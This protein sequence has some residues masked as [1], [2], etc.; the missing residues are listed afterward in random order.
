MDDAQLREALAA[1][2]RGD[3]AAFEEIYAALSVP[4]YTIILRICGAREPAEDA[5]QEVFLKLFRAP[6]GPDVRKPRAYLFQMAR[7]QALDALRQRT[8]CEDLDDHRDLEQHCPDPAQRLDLERALAALSLEERQLVTLHV[9]GGLKFRELAQIMSLPLG[10]ALWKYHR[11]I[12]KLR[13]QLSGG[14]L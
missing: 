1:L 6:P 13:T 10:T 8:C 2:R 3:R 5:L 12:D 7:N 11:A 14:A 9:N 4:L